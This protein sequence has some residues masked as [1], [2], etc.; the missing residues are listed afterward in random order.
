[1]FVFFL[2]T[3]GGERKESV[4]GVLKSQKIHE[5][6][7]TNTYYCITSAAMLNAAAVQRQVYNDHSHTRIYPI[8]EAGRS[9]CNHKKNL[10]SF[11]IEIL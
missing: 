8:A 10:K 11:K 3:I 7:N 5:A 2:Q 4:P 6:L 1:M 9:Y